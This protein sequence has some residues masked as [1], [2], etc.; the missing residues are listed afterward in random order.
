MEETSA[1]Y[2][3]SVYPARQK[4][5]YYARCKPLRSRLDGGGVVTGPADRRVR[6]LIQLPPNCPGVQ[7]S[8]EDRQRPAGPKKPMEEPRSVAAEHVWIILHR[9]PAHVR[10]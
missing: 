6:A 1:A 2:L 4:R 8:N 10:S 7:S 9:P 5:S 3:E